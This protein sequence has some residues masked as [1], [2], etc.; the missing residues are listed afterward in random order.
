MN[1]TSALHN[2]IVR[3]LRQHFESTMKN[4][5]KFTG[6]EKVLYS[7]RLSMDNRNGTKG[8]EAT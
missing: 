7:L 8:D 2:S 4:Y 3:L 5:R 1:H 6:G